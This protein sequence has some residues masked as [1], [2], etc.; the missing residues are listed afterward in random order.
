M[1]DYFLGSSDE[2]SADKVENKASVDKNDVWSITD[3][4]NSVSI[5]EVCISS[6]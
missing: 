6:V 4:D 1:V 3:D 2:D 5:E